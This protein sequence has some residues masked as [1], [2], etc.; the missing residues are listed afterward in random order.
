MWMEEHIGTRINQN[1]VDEAAGT[2]AKVIATACPF[3]TTM[4]KDGINETG[5]EGVE[6]KDIAEIVAASL[7][8]PVVTGAAISKRR[9]DQLIAGSA[10]FRPGGINPARGRWRGD[11]ASLTSLRAARRAS[12]LV[13]A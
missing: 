10:S 12:A 5:G 9:A 4:M 2:G 6:V 11:P 7:K 1:R 8:L 3:C 13:G